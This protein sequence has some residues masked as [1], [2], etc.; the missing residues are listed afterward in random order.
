MNTL[1]IILL[2]AAAVPLLGR[3]VYFSAN[4]ANKYPAA[5]SEDKPVQFVVFYNT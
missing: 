4:A 3:L 2:A 5:E 1:S